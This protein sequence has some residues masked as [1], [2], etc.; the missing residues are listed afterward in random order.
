M[1][2]E[3]LSDKG[4]EFVNARFGKLLNYEGIEL[5]VCRKPDVKCA[6]VERTNRTFKS[7]LYKWLTRNNTY[8]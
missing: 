3:L 4:K 7:K 8:R 6:V 5:R 1:P 2:L